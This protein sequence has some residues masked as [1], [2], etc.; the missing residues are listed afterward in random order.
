MPT[1]GDD[2]SQTATKAGGKG[3]VHPSG[4]IAALFSAVEARRD[5]LVDTTVGLLKI[6]TFNPPGDNYLE[7]CD[8]LESR[9]RPA[10]FDCIKLRAKDAPGD[11]DATPAG[12]SSHGARVLAPARAS[13][14]M[15]IPILSRWVKAGRKIRLVRIS[16]VTASMGA[17]PVT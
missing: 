1:A 10:G 16:R 14:S 9:L 2:T 8:H 6:P 3:R 11:S 5:A 13:I 15:A 17:V 12:T 7:I 4:R